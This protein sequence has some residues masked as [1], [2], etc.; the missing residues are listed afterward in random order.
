MANPH[1]ND[2][3][4]R[5][6]RRTGERR[7]DLLQMFERLEQKVDAFIAGF[8][9]GDPDGHRRYHE[10]MIERAKAGT[11]FR[12]KLLFELT[13]WGLLGFTG[14]LCLSLW[15]AFLRGPK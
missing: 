3:D 13:K 9:D 7:A 8:P 2:D 4:A 6:E 14:W 15:Q 11:E 12:R 1:R 5:E 10:A